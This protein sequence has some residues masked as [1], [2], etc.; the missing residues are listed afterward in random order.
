M[1][2]M[3]E[4]VTVTALNQYI[5]ALMSRD[6][7]LSGI[8]V[9]GEI[10]NCK[11]HTSGHLYFSLKDDGGV[12][13]CVAFRSAASRLT[14]VPKDGMKVIAFGSVNVYSPAGQYQLYVQSMIPDGKGDLFA[15]FEQLK[16]KLEAEGLFDPERKKEIPKFPRT[17]GVITSSSGAAVE[18]IINIV[19]RRYP[20]AKLILY[21]VAVQGVEAPPD[22]IRAV[23][24]FDAHPTDV[25]II[26]RGGGSMEDLWCF[27]DEG[28]ARA[29][30]DA[31][32]P[33]ISAVGH[34]TDFTICDFVA[35]LRAPTPSAAAELAVPDR[36]E[37]AEKIVS[38]QQKAVTALRSRARLAET[39]LARYA[40]SAVMKDPQRILYPY[41]TALAAG[42]EK[43]RLAVRQR[44]DGEK[45]RLSVLAE[46]LQGLSPLAVLARGYGAISSADGRLIR[47][48]SDLTTGAEVRI[49]LADGTADAQI[50]H[51]TEEDSHEE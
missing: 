41:A 19:T 45:H 40:E 42:E 15:A 1:G 21:P 32:V 10:S 28:L 4:A 16:A 9:R 7:I 46:R 24:Y 25:V 47:H 30:A 51:V 27:N 35:D 20:L 29:I 12:L 8:A 50:T 37:L 6:D 31:Q 34:E 44:T 3:Q 26:G 39:R 38:L 11:H 36:G 22:L 5:S 49:R 2:L 33:I 43:L 23:R 17:V 48:V 13:K 18:D 14:F